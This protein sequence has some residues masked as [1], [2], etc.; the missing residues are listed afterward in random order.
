MTVDSKPPTPAPPRRKP[1]A[2]KPKVQPFHY[3]ASGLPDVWLVN[4]FQREDTPD[5][6]AVRIE[7]VDGLHRELARAIVADRRAFKPA[8]LRYLRR[9]LSLSQANVA[10]LLGISEQTVARWEKGETSIDPSGERLI[11]FIVTEALG[12]DVTVREALRDL[13]AADEDRHG[14]GR[15]LQHRAGAWHDMRAA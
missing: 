11:R 8:E 5:G 2:R 7:D 1:A 6:P 15:T 13:A 10:A 14:E 12:E 3:V 9:F 4:G